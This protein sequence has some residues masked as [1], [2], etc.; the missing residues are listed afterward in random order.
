MPHSRYAA[1]LAAV[2]LFVSL[3]SNSQWI[4]QASGTDYNLYAVHFINNN[5]GFIGSNS[6]DLNNFI[7]GEIIRTSN[8]GENWQRVLIDTNL[9]VKDIYFL[10]PLTGFAVGGTYT[11]LGRVYKTT[12]SGLNWINTT[13]TELNSHIYNI[14]FVN[15]VT[16]FLGGPWGVFKTTNA[17]SNWIFTS[18]ISN[19]L[20]WGKVLF[21]DENTGIFT[22]DNA[23]IHKT[24]NSG[25]NWFMVTLSNSRT[26]RDVYQIDDNS[27][28]IV[29]DSI[30]VKST[31]RGAS[32]LNILPP[33]NVQFF[34]V[35][36]IN[37][38][39]GYMTGLA[40]AWKSTNSGMIWNQVYSL[41]N[42]NLLATNFIDANTG[43]VVGDGGVVYKT[44]TGGVIGIEPISNEIPKDFVLYQNYP[45]PFNPTTNIKFSIPKAA[46]VT[47]AVYDML[48]R[49]I[50]TLVNENLSPA[51][52]EVKWDAAGFSSG[53]YFYKLL[54]PD[55]SLVKKMSVIK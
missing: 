30:I 27:C 26:K 50:Q 49:E 22:G 28:L 44:T 12:D 25:I 42:H 41:P 53:I 38:N 11:T 3:S 31:D 2:L 37:P 19:P 40:G 54:T 33:A 43:Y 20:G 5:T 18:L 21:F 10:N 32:W 48:G 15:P 23:R 17:G 46:F 7:G 55:F 14:Q 13:P 29:G 47:L 9:R 24:T 6:W 51:T 16:G 39:T 8:A 45:N 35:Q 4:Q 34:G 36:F 52:Y 1:V